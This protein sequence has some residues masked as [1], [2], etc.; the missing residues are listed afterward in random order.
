MTAINRIL[1]AIADPS[2]RAQPALD[3]GVQLA[4][5]TG[6]QIEVF[7]CLFNPY[8]QGER[9]YGSR[10]AARDI[11]AL[12]EMTRR[13]LEQ[14]A[15]ARAGAK[16]RMRVSVRWDYPAHEGIVRQ[17]MRHRADVVVAESHR[18][19]KTARLFLSNTDWQLIR[20]C[21][22]PLLLVKTS[23]A[24]T[25]AKVLAAIDPLHT[26]AKP[27]ALDPRILKIGAQLARAFGSQLH[28]VHAHAPLIGYTPGLM[29]E[30]L[31][32]R[33]TG[34]QAREYAKRVRKNVIAETRRF[35][36]SERRVHVIE[37]EPGRILPQ[38]ARRLGAQIMVMGAVSRSGLKRLFIGNTA[39]RVI[40]E[41]P[42]DVCVVK[43]PG[44][45]TLVSARPHHLPVMVPPL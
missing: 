2:S 9:I 40:D 18:H 35:A 1:V 15:A 3:K 43:P 33:I 39:E 38:T 31:P 19:R 8:V 30:P 5:R 4:R 24:W 28:A 37:G 13:R 7:H 16:L 44:F 12:V 22:V 14:C 6:A 17:A 34:R 20:L 11:E 27:T 41:L 25:G 42:C 21:P 32:Y 45:R 26:H 29:T 36:L 10:G 23:R